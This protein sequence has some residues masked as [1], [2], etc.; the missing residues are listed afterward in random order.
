MQR[1]K[2]GVLQQHVSL[3]RSVFF[4]LRA[5]ILRYGLVETSVSSGLS[6]VTFQGFFPIPAPVSVDFQSTCE[7][8][9]IVPS[10]ETTGQF[11]L[12]QW[13]FAS[14]GQTGKGVMAVGMCQ[15]E[16][17]EWHISNISPQF[18][19]TGLCVRCDESLVDRRLQHE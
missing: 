7:H 3:H 10:F 8:K 14:P 19:L 4:N 15:S 13:G 5:I 9:Q 17:H 16:D 18:C 2:A 11:L 12:T 1:K 6:I